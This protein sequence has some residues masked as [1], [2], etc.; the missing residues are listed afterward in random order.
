MESNKQIS[1]VNFVQLVPNSQ[2]YTDLKQIENSLQYS[3]ERDHIL[4]GI[5]NSINQGYTIAPPKLPI[6]KH[7]W[8]LYRK[9]NSKKP[10]LC[11]VRFIDKNGVYNIRYAD[12]SK[13]IKTTDL[14]K[15]VKWI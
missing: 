7:D 4:Q 9:G 6:G 11:Q 2:V 8:V 10:I 3:I 15:F 14:S 13:L 5:R 12:G 1:S